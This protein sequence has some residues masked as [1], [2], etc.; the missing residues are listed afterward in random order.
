MQDKHK[1]TSQMYWL[2]LDLEK[3]YEQ[4]DESFKKI[5]DFH[6]YARNRTLTILNQAFDWLIDD[7]REDASNH[8]DID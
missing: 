2:L 6:E 7:A 8:T 4:K 1:L 3:E 5:V